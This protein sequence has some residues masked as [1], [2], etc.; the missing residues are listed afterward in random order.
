MDIVKL[1]QNFKYSNW[2]HLLCC[3][4][5]LLLVLQL[6]E[7]YYYYIPYELKQIRR[8]LSLCLFLFSFISS[9]NMWFVWYQLKHICQT[10]SQ[11]S[12]FYRHIRLN[13]VNSLSS[14]YKFFF[15]MKTTWWQSNLYYEID[16][17][18]THV[19]C[20]C[21][22]FVCECSPSCLFCTPITGASQTH[23]RCCWQEQ[24]E[25]R[26]WCHES[27]CSAYGKWSVIIVISA[28]YQ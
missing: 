7:I 16:N 4:P 19:K 10:W 6:H 27:K 15:V 3:S 1:L 12:L 13:K 26:S 5:S 21:L 23:S 18:A 2:V 22:S 8:K 14:D 24:L 17:P 25:D 9:V 20:V 11:N 28:C